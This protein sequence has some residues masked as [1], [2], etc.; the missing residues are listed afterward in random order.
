M[1]GFALH[2]AASHAPAA[3]KPDGLLEMSPYSMAFEERFTTLGTAGEASRC[4]FPFQYQNQW[5]YSCE[6]TTQIATPEGATSETGWCSTSQG[7]KAFKYSQEWGRCRPRGY[8]RP[9]AR[10]TNGRGESGPDQSCKFPIIEGQLKH[11]DCVPD[12]RR[13]AGVC[14]GEGWMQQGGTCV[15]GN[16]QQ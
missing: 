7:D 11:W 14:K 9:A 10:Y 13:K 3:I 16:W 4:I 5:V 2:A 1:D 8:T 15:K 12:E 6:G